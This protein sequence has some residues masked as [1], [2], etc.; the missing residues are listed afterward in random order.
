VQFWWLFLLFFFPFIGGVIGLLLQSKKTKQL[1][2]LLAFSGA[3]L[4]SITILSLMPEVF[5]GMGSKAGYYI[6]IGFFLQIVLDFFTKGIEHGH[7]H[8]HEFKKGFPV[9][10]FLALG[11][12]AFFEGIGLGGGIWSEETQ[13]NLVFAIGLHE[14]PAA[15]ALAIVLKSVY[16]QSSI[17]YLWIAV[18]SLMIPI[19]M[20]VGNQL[21]EYQ[22]L[23]NALAAI[24]IGI[25]LHIATTILFENNESHTYGKHK[26]VAI[27]LGLIIA[28][29]AV[30]FHVH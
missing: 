25:F 21:S 4:V 23:L 19:G 10:V 30:N 20:L 29:L 26:L 2:L 17:N 7:L 5:E 22:E 12:H 13:M 27:A 15:F 1:K 11:L 9:S 28:L 8:F 6:L 16:N 24:V 3:F 18:Y 14:L